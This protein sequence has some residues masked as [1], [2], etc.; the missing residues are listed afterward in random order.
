MYTNPSLLL[1]DLF[2]VF[3]SSVVE[4]KNFSPVLAFIFRVRAGEWAWVG[5]WLL[6]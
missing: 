1:F 4:K 3:V 2:M 6:L 5:A